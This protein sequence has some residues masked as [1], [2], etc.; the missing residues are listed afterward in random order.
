MESRLIVGKGKT[1]KVFLDH[2]KSLY[3]PRGGDL[4]V[5]VDQG[6][7]GSPREVLRSAVRIAHRAEYSSCYLM[8]DGDCCEE[9]FEE[10]ALN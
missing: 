7:G 6:K 5:K 3:L 4:I 1:E 10:E 9:G 8:V 2:L